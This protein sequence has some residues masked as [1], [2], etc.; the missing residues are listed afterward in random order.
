MH[1]ALANYCIDCS[2]GFCSCMIG[3]Q[4]NGTAPAT[5]HTRAY[6][7]TRYI[8]DPAPVRACDGKRGTMHDSIIRHL[9][10]NGEPTFKFVNV[11]P[12]AMRTKRSAH[13]YRL[14]LAWELGP[15]SFNTIGTHLRLIERM[16]GS[17]QPRC[18]RC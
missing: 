11:V 15:K 2:D 17:S 18:D 10:T 4:R 5:P 1:R 13:T 7:H 14:G 12:T 6:M 16:H 3:G 9:K 8:R